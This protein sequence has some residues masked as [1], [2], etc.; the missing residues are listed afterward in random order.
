MFG[1]TSDATEGAIPLLHSMAPR[2]GW[3]LTGACKKDVF[4]WVRPVDKTQ[5][6][7]EYLQH[8]VVVSTPH[9]E[10]LQSVCRKEEYTGYSGFVETA[11]SM[12]ELIGSSTRRGSG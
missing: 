4:W 11:L 7:F 3:K 8:T 5:V 1:Y 9:A 6:T 2:L 10:P 12:E